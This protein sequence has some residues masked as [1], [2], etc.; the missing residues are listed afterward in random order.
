MICLISLL[1]FGQ[2]TTIRGNLNVLGTVTANGS[3]ITNINGTSLKWPTNA[4]STATINMSLPWSAVST[5]NN[6]NITG[7]T[8]LDVSGTNVQAITC[9]ITNSAGSAAVKTITM[10]AGSIDL[11]NTGLT[12]YNTNQGALTVVIYPGLGTNFTWLGK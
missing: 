7:F 11:L 10:P 2:S 1:S 9:I 5:N 3:G 8:G 6:I 4:A 12:L